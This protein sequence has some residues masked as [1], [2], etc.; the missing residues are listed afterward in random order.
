MPSVL[1]T[2]YHGNIRPDEKCYAPDSPY[3]QAVCLERINLDKLMAT[4]NEDEKELF[5]KYCDAHDELENITHYDIYT[6]ALKF[7]MLLTAEVFMGRDEI[8]G[9]Q[10]L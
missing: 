1:E 3:M 10:Q 2:L 6:Y 4:L 7:G 9:V 8:C 5:G